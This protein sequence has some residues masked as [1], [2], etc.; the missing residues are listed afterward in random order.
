M[1]GYAILAKGEQPKSLDEKTYLVKS[2]SGN[3]SYHVAIVEDEWRCE[4]PDFQFRRVVCKHIHAVR[5]WLALRKK[6]EKSSLFNLREEVLEA[7]Y[8]RFC[9][10]PIII[11]Q[12]IRKCRFGFKQ[13]YLCKDCGKKFVSEDAF[14]RMQYDPRII[15]ATLDLYYKGTSLRKTSDHLEQFY[16]IRI[17]YA[18]ILRW[19]RKFGK[20]IEEYAST[21]EP[22]LSEQWHTDEMAINVKGK[23][24][25]LWNVMDKDT[26]FMLA[27]LISEKRQIQDARKVFQKAKEVGKSKPGRVVTDGLHAYE[28]AFKKEFFTLRNPR[29]K[30]VRMPRFTDETNNNIVERLQGTIRERDK[31]LRAF[32]QEESAQ[33]ILDGFRAYYNFIRPHQALQGRT[34]AEVSNINLNLKG[35]KWLEFINQAKTSKCNNKKLTKP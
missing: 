33:K 30:H 12:G 13:V 19:I 17:N 15:T 32:K 10:S 25:W 21:L 31:V 11:K 4:C 5:F 35:N 6:I 22:K 7:K 1:R 16:G 29:T 26:R 9:G 14:Q 27:S 8:C 28:D 20:M 34:P 3:G 2:Q 24:M 23:W 18:T